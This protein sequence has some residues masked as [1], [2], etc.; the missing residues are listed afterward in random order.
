[1][2]KNNNMNNKMSMAQIDHVRN[3]SDKK[4][5]LPLGKRRD[6]LYEQT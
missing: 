4:T 1:M 3:S 2:K 5:H 6:S